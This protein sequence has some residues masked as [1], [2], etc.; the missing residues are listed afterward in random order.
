[1]IWSVL[2][3]SPDVWDKLDTPYKLKQYEMNTIKKLCDILE[4]FELHKVHK[5]KLVSALQS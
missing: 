2:H 4:P 5:C 1:M 3:V